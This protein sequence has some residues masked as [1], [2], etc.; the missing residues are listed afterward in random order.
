MKETPSSLL[1]LPILLLAG[2]NAF[3]GT[4][5][6][7]ISLP[8]SV[9]YESNPQMASSGASVWRASL[10]PRL[11]L[12][13]AMD[14]DELSTDLAVNE[15]RSSDTA[16]SSE[17]TD[18]QLQLSWL[19]HL[20]K[21][22]FSLSGKYDRA[23]TRTTEFQDTGYVLADSTRT[24]K[25]MFA[26]GQYQMSERT[27]LSGHVEYDRVTYNNN[28]F[29]NY[30]TTSG[31]LTL[32]YSLTEKI[33]PF[34]SLSTTHYVPDLENALTTSLDQ[35]MG[36][37]GF[38]W[39][40]SEIWDATVYIGAQNVSGSSSSSGGVGGASMH[41]GGDRSDMNF[42]LSHSVTPSGFGGFIKANQ[43]TG[44]WSY[45]LS[46]RNKTGVNISWRKNYDLN[47]ITTSQVGLWLSHELS[48][49]WSTKLTYLHKTQDQAG[50]SNHSDMVGLS[51]AYQRS[52]F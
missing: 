41:Y 17:R 50:I 14:V 38:K 12:D 7:S 32:N 6:K 13:Y 22:D 35:Y 34:F 3:A 8:M 15:V 49:S 24:T 39:L 11:K 33:Q 4:W 30:K 40:F 2:S 18:P 46:E 20:S 43:A 10:S 48:L 9:D 37:A 27:S 5:Q 16:V 36:Q 31:N 23:S 1:L 52:D 21:G 45:T 42:S 28:A 29:T 44:S 51:L 19:H 47:N 25:S 26:D